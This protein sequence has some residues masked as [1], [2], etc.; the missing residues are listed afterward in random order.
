MTFSAG[1]GKSPKDSRSTRGRMESAGKPA[2]HRPASRSQRRKL[3]AG[4]RGGA[5][6]W[7]RQSS[8]KHNEMIG[9]ETTN[10]PRYG[11]AIGATHPEEAR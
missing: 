4:R 8:L 5:H 6:R 7:G 3:G 10:N 2:H 11:M 1:I 9:L